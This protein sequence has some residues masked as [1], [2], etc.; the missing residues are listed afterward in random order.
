[1]NYDREISNHLQW[2]SM[3]QYLCNEDKENLLS[4]NEIEKPNLC[5]L[6]KWILSEEAKKQGDQN[7][8]DHLHAVHK[9]FH[10]VAAKML[11][12]SRSS[13]KEE[14]KKLSPQ[15]DDLSSQLIS[16]INQMRM[17]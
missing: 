12:L 7:L 6:G 15:L 10:Q 8:I 13:K 2:K 5:A 1:M 9:E 4:I 16:L 11:S 17:Q 3:L 14:A